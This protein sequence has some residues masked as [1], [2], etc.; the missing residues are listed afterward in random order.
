MDGSI[1]VEK[2]HEIAEEVHDLI[3]GNIEEVKHCMVHV[4]PE[5]H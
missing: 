3:E 1:S 2:G 4:E 5:I